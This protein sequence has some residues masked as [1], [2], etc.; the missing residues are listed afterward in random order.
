MTPSARR[1]EE[2][3]AELT[4]GFSSAMMSARVSSTAASQ[5][6]YQVRTERA[7]KQHQERQKKEAAA[8]EEGEGAR[9]SCAPSPYPAC[10]STSRQGFSLVA[11]SRERA[12]LT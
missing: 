1:G 11:A 9:T 6:R 10:A 7:H 8:V 12:T 3:G 2:A 4:L 5:K